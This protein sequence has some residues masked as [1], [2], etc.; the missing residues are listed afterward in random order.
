MSYAV[1][2]PSSDFFRGSLVVIHEFFN[3][4]ITVSV[5]VTSLYNVTLSTSDP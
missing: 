5:I 3:K 2:I 4:N 1:N